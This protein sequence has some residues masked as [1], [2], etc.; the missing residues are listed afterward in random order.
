MPCGN[1][2]LFPPVGK[3]DLDEP[4]LSDPWQLPKPSPDFPEDPAPERPRL[5]LPSP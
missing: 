4:M 3:R 2:N 1:G 5:I